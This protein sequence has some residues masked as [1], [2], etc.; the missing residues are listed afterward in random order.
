MSTLT[1]TN[2]CTYVC[3]LRFFH[4]FSAS[5]DCI[6]LINEEFFVSGSQDGLVV[7]VLCAM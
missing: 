4:V 7:L 6:K 2:L 1:N 5:I 3:M